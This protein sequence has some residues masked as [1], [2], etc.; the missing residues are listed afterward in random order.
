MIEFIPFQNKYSFKYTIVW[1][2]WCFIVDQQCFPLLIC[3]RL[4]EI[5]AGV[6]LRAKSCSNTTGKM[7]LN[8]R[9]DEDRDLA[10]NMTRWFRLHCQ[11][12][13]KYGICVA[14]PVALIDVNAFVCFLGVCWYTVSGMSLWQVV[15][16]HGN[17]NVAGKA[18]VNA[19]VN[20]SLFPRTFRKKEKNLKVLI[21]IDVPMTI[22]I[23]VLF[24]VHA[25]L[26]ATLK[27]VTTPS[28]CTTGLG[29]CHRA[30]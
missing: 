28:R 2:Q 21:S 20:K 19:E 26:V 8:T 12:G 17:T 13:I 22:I 16:A 5:Q 10:D 6:S 25:L 1:T 11:I 9:E 23:N 3:I 7:G 14:S 24:L 18:D 15:E 29:F 30:L 4:Q 27:K